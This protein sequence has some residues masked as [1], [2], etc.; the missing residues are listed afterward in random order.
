MRSRAR[1]EQGELEG[2]LRDGVRRFLGVPFATPP[3]G[4][5]RFRAPRPAEPWTGVRRAVD[6]GPP[7]YQFDLSN[8]AHVAELVARRD[9]GVEGILPFPPAF[10]ADTIAESSSEDCLYVD[11]YAPENP[12]GGPLP[13]Y[14]YYHGGANVTNSAP[15]KFEFQAGERL[16]RAENIVVVQPQYRNG[17]LGWTHF[18][19]ID[20]ELG[21]AVNLGLKD[22]I[23]ALEWIAANVAAFGGDP[24]NITIGGESAGGTAVSHLIANPR[25][26]RLARRAILQSLSPINTWSTQREPEARAVAQLYADVLRGEDL[27]SVDPDEFLALQSVLIRLFHPDRVVPW[28]PHG[29]VVDGD[30]IADLPVLQLAEHGLG[31]PGFEVMIGF[32]KDEWQFFRGHSPTLTETDP[33]TAK[34]VLAQ[35]FGDDGAERVYAAYAALYPDHPP[36]H[37]LSDVLACVYF[38]LSSMEIARTLAAQGS[39]VY[40][41]QFSYDHPGL[42]GYLRALHTG[43]LP[44]VFRTTTPE[45]LPAFRSLHGADMDEVERVAAEFGALYAG[46]IR[47]GRPG[48][49][50]ARYEPEDETIL[51]FGVPVES[52]P[53]L[54]RGERAA[55]AAGGVTTIAQLEAHV[56]AAMRAELPAALA[57]I[58][59]P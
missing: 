43:T 30:L 10:M 46:F 12:G 29:G 28:R 39:D 22:Q 40:V 23:A 9:P 42:G 50:W 16:A 32:A 20:P 24:R 6:H 26:R 8:R 59:A 37:L 4:D 33:R 51:W 56:L 11:V 44:F 2:E 35:V 14:V 5:L 15:G 3:V 34:A 25:T 21:E 54:L 52:R 31:D 48:P 19:L 17:A 18:G 58:A 27:C 13:V 36:A 57:R 41:F 7:S 49:Q 38:K 53:G 55:F 47:E 1:V 45:H